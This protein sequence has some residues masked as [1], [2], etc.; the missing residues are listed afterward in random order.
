MARHRGL[1]RPQPSNITSRKSDN[2]N[3]S[4]ASCAIPFGQVA[5]LSK[6]SDT[7]GARTAAFPVTGGHYVRLKLSRWRQLGKSCPNAKVEIPLLFAECRENFVFLGYETAGAARDRKT[8]V[9]PHFY[10]LAGP[11]GRYTVRLT[12]AS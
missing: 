6:N 3:R 4:C 7:P 8:S 12:N 9:A 5:I 10:N 11:F 1:V 2:R